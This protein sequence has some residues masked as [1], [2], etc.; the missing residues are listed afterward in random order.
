MTAQIGEQR[1]ISEQD[2]QRLARCVVDGGIAVLPTDTVYGLCCAPDD[3]DAARRLYALKGRP[4]ARPAA[5]MFFALAPALEMLDELHPDERAVLQALLPGPV[6][7]LL[8]NP[9]R[10]FPPAC[11]TDPDTLGLRV[12]RLP[13]NL[14]ALEAVRAPV[15]QTSANMSG[16]SDARTLEQVPQSLRAGAD[17]VL[18]G[19]ELP[20]RPSTVIDLRD[21]AEH[22]RW[23]V[24]REG[25]LPR[26]QVRELLTTL[27]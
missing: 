12:P 10:R 24:L 20:G 9:A 6:T 17:C 7:L 2:A 3:E 5:V 23:H 22:R 16:E 27:D 25:A 11:R 1:E 14:L 18:D 21:F 15:M 19:G 13:Q 4:P 26:A 8:A